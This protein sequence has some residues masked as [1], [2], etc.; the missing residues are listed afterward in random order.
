MIDR[1]PEIQ[2][3]LRQFAEPDRLTAIEL[4]LHLRFRTRDAYAD[5]IVAELEDMS[6][7]CALYA[8]RRLPGHQ[9]SVW[10]PQGRFVHRTATA[11]GSEDLVMSV[12]AQLTRRDDRKY[13]DHPSIQT[14]RSRRIKQLVFLEDSVGSGDRVAAFIRRFF[15]QPSIRSWWSYGK[16]R[17]HVVA[18]VR[19]ETGE[20]AIVE[21]LPGSDH[22][23][24]VHP[25]STKVVF[26]GALVY[27]A[28][29]LRGRWGPQAA[30]IR[31]LCL[32]TTQIPK[33]RRL[34]YG[35][36]MA[37]QIFF[38]SVP[39]NIPGVLFVSNARWQ[40]LFPER[41]FPAWLS[42]LLSTPPAPVP[43]RPT[44]AIP[45]GVLLSAL[46]LIKGGLTRF[47]GLGHRLGISPGHLAHVLASGV[48]SGF[49]TPQFR[50]TSRGRDVVI[51]S[52]QATGPAPFDRSL[53]LPQSWCAGQNSNQPPLSTRRGVNRT[54]LRRPTR[55]ESE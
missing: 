40:P 30:D 3:W 9:L 50:L 48:E 23:S 22:P 51:R 55:E 20:A 15:D 18:P 2:A 29:W 10:N 28:S 52:G 5:W 44:G 41:V 17:L 45:S 36:V 16:I 12:I 39:N 27:S 31:S 37:N 7:P 49:L 33:H 47:V 19:S 54:T 1:S 11:R 42:T 35:D 24:R 32:R 46:V 53:Y 8:V 43:S 34:G 13:L 21:Q 14:L 25:K 26:H 6:G 4:L 38:H